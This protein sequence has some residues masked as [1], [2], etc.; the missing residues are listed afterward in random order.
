V[1]KVRQF[2][3]IHTEA[4]TGLATL[5]PP[6]RCG[7]CHTRFHVMNKA[8]CW[9]RTYTK[10]IAVIKGIHRQIYTTSSFSLS[11]MQGLKVSKVLTNNKLSGRW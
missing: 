3:A 7:P 2:A 9:T 10:Y 1:I 4:T 5:N 6:D 8:F 11:I